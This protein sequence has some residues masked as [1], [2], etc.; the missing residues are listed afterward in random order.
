L[1]IVLGLIY[2]LLYFIRRIMPNLAFLGRL[3]SPLR[4]WLDKTIILYEPLAIL[5][6]VAVFIMIKPGFHGLMAGA[7]IIFSIDHVRNYFQGRL[8][9]TNKTLKVGRRIKVG[10]SEGIIVDLGRFGVDVRTDEGLSFLPYQV[11]IRN[12]YVMSSGDKILSS[13]DYT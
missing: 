2:L 1:I 12:G 3:R 6:M 8:Y 4:K 5:L 13:S 11:L 7:L 10:G 9:L